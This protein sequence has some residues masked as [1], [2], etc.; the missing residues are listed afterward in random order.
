[1]ADVPQFAM[2]FRVES[3]VVVEVEQDSTEEIQQCVEAVLRTIVG[4]R[5][6]DA[7]DFGVPDE[8]FVQ[9]MPS[10]SADVYVAA[11]EEQEPRARVLGRA[12][13]LELAAK[14]VTIGSEGSGV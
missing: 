3:G 7:P 1:M 8:T 6:L 4:T 14:H 10:P 5:L 12:Q 11:I 9:Q 13:L 2:P